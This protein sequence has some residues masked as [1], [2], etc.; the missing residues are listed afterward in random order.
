MGLGAFILCLCALLSI[1]GGKKEKFTRD[2]LIRGYD[3]TRLDLA[4]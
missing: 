1:C 2:E 3:N 4:K